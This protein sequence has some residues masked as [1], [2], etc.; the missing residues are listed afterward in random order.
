[1]KVIINLSK[2]EWNKL[3]SIEKEHNIPKEEMVRDWLDLGEQF[4]SYV[5]ELIIQRSI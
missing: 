4:D 5:N 2:E 1:M 3:E